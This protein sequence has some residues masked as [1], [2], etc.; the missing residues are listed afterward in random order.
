MLFG[1]ILILIFI[2]VFV[3]FFF[4]MFSSVFCRF[5]WSRFGLG[6]RGSR[7]L[8]TFVFWFMLVVVEF[9]GGSYIDGVILDEE[10][11]RVVVELEGIIF[12]SV[13]GYRR[14]GYWYVMLFIFECYIEL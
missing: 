14:M 8:L 2:L 12:G 1:V 4:W 10:I 9:E 3:L 7:L 11:R 13:F 6:L 5:Y